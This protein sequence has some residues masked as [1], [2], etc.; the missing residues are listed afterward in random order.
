MNRAFSRVTARGHLGRRSPEAPGPL[1]LGDPGVG[2][3]GGRFHQIS[4]NYLILQT[5][6]GMEVMERV[7]KRGPPSRN[8]LDYTA[9]LGRLPGMFSV[10]P[11]D[12]AIGELTTA[13]P[14]SDHV[15]WH[16]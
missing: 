1:V 14:C 9:E 8:L 4:Q 2:H 10:P 7:G 11:D 6:N 13:Q 12:T 5:V 16:S 15:Q 3:L